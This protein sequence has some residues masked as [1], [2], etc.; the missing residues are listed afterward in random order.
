MGEKVKLELEFPVRAS[1]SMLYTF[2]STPSGLAE[3]FCDDV[4]SRSDRFV[5]KWGDSEESA[6]LVRKRQDT[7]VQFKWEEDTSAQKFSFEFRIVVDD[8]TLDATLVVTDYVDKS[9]V[10]EMRM[11][12]NS[13][14]HTLLHTIGA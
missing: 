8:I 13:Q 4:E 2:L 11:L 9:D 1:A 3:W 6:Q 10:N 5:F 14:I 12:W 7:F